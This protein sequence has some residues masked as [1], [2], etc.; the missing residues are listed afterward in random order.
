VV[1]EGVE[2]EA[3]WDALTKLGCDYAQGHYVSPAV[4]SGELMQ[5]LRSRG[6]PAPH[7]SNVRDLHG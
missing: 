4:S 2:T 7:H 1:A 3:E 5:W 6:V